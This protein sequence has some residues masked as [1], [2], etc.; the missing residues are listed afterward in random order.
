MIKLLLMRSFIMLSCFVMSLSGAELV[1]ITDMSK[2][3]PAEFSYKP[4]QGKWQKI[5][6][7]SDTVSGIMVGALSYINAPEVTLPIDI[8]GWHKIYIGYWN[9][10]FD[11]EW[12]NKAYLRV[13]LSDQKGFRLMRDD[14]SNGKQNATFLREIF[15]DCTDVTGKNIVLS[16][17][18]G[19]KGAK[20][21]YA[22]IK[23]VPMAENEIKSVIADRKNNSTRNMTATIDG[24]SYFYTTQFDTEEDILSM[25]ELYRYSD[26]EK[27]LWAVN[28]GDRVNYPAK[29]KDAVFVDKWA[30]P[31]LRGNIV[32][33]TDRLH[34]ELQMRQTLTK[35][36]QK[37]VIAQNIAAKHCH[38]MGIRFDIM[39][40]LGIT[41]K[42]PALQPHDDFC[43]KHPDCRQ[44]LADGIIVQK[45]SYAFPETQNFMLD[46][47][48]ESA[49]RIDCDGVNLCFV[50]GPHLLWFEGP[51]LER[52]EK[53]F[54]ED[55]QKAGPMDPRIQ[56]IRAEIL[57]EFV[58]KARSCLDEVGA[59]KG[60]KLEL[61]VWVWPST[62]GVWL[63]RRPYEEGVDV[64]SW[65]KAGLL[66]SVICQEGID[67][68]YMELGRQHNCQFMLFTG[69]R[70][71]KAMSPATIVKAHEKGIEKFAY[72][73]MDCFQNL[74]Q[75]WGWL[76]ISGHYK[77]LKTWESSEHET[78]SIQLQTLDGI[79]VNEALSAAVYSGG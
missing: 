53:R 40:R 77:E 48:K 32:P 2:C 56:K 75:V 29:V 67:N 37:N 42:V 63:G 46:L 61:S 47:I 5:K 55:A 51:I 27:V 25:V 33:T 39:M 38:E 52:F 58:Q 78:D 73:D 79:N 9:P 16:K 4:E 60:R 21:Y 64:K 18:N 12:S 14:H 76:R 31:D 30:S 19:L 34:G 69:Y 71:T 23:L 74:S 10:K 72:W 6:Y 62:Q 65:I 35:F 7:T 43:E 57:T 45:A 1:Y 11:A 8:K 41:G 70:G 24:M 50:R 28:Y 36:A 20:V 15:F 44:K 17:P 68:D 26:V 3:H 59:K 22:Y 13:K 49:E 54:G 66:D